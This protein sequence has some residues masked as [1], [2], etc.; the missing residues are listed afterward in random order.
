[1]DQKNIWIG[2][3][4]KKFKCRPIMAGTPKSCMYVEAIV[5]LLSYKADLWIGMLN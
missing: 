4:M 5:H 2:F 3:K 1:M